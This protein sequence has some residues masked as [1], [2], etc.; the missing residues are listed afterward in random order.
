M[1]GCALCSQARLDNGFPGIRL[2]CPRQHWVIMQKLGH[3]TSQVLRLA[4]TGDMQ[5][6][7]QC[8]QTKYSSDFGPMLDVS[9]RAVRP[10]LTHGREAM[11]F[12]TDP[13]LPAACEG[14]FFM[15]TPDA[16]RQPPTATSSG[17]Q[18]ASAACVPPPI[19]FSAAHL[20]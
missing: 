2:M 15:A 18:Q 20:Q 8:F 6:L 5:G 19:A 13:D 10:T 3:F 7:L 11:P 16:P 14:A 12:R 9:N 4:G 1:T 17:A